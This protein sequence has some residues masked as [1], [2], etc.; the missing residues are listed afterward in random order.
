MSDVSGCYGTGSDDYYWAPLSLAAL[1]GFIAHYFG[2]LRRPRFVE[3]GDE[4]S[5]ITIPEIGE[6]RAPK[7]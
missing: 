4:A 2:M 5:V 3:I 1:I 7:P 6:V